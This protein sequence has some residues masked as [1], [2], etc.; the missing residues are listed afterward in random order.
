VLLTSAVISVM[1]AV[2]CDLASGK[3]GIIGISTMPVP[4]LHGGTGTRRSVLVL[5]QLAWSVS[6]NRALWPTVWPRVRPRAL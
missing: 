3:Y 2:P 4:V 6:Y 1:R 5:Y